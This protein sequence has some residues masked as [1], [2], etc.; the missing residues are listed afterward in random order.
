MHSYGYFLWSPGISSFFRIF[1][2]KTNFLPSR[3]SGDMNDGSLWRLDIYRIK[4]NYLL[5]RVSS[6]VL[7]L[8]S[9]EVKLIDMLIE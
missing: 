4:E 7:I 1:F 6:S 9:C 2:K 5:I 8:V 3:F